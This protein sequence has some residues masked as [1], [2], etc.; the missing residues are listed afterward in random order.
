MDTKDIPHQPLSEW[1]PITNK[2]DLAV[3]GK[4]GEEIGEL[5]EQASRLSTAIFRCVIQ[6]IDERE[7]RTLKLNKQWL[8]DEIA[9]AMAMQLMAIGRLGL[10]LQAIVER[11]DRK[12][13]YKEPWFKSLEPGAALY[14]TNMEEVREAPALTDIS[15]PAPISERS[16]L[17][18]KPY[19]CVSCGVGF[20][21]LMACKLLGCK[22][23]TVEQAK[24]RAAA[25]ILE[26]VKQAQERA[27]AW[28]N[29]GG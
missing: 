5:A 19:F 3:L 11:R 17:D 29:D 28:E 26:T 16:P 14:Q 21:E 15:V 18:S 12:M 27:P 10:D 6:G 9:D 8:Q 20:A 22:L 1:Q 4:M 13:N 25:H 7:P 24:E 2:H 23:E